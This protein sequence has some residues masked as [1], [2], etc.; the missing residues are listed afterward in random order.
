MALDLPERLSAVFF[1]QRRVSRHQAKRIE[2]WIVS[3]IVLPH[4]LGLLCR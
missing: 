4:R 1:L 2:Q 3:L